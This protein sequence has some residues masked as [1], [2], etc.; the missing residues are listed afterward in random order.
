MDWIPPLAE[1]A[2]GLALSPPQYA[3]IAEPVEAWHHVAGLLTAAQ[4]DGAAL[5]Q[6]R[7]HALHPL[8]WAG[9]SWGGQTAPSHRRCSSRCHARKGREATVTGRPGEGWKKWP[10]P[11]RRKPSQLPR[12][13]FPCQPTSAAASTAPGCP[14]YLKLAGVGKILQWL[15]GQAWRAAKNNLPSTAPAPRPHSAL[16]T[17]QPAQLESGQKPAWWGWVPHSKQQGTPGHNPSLV[18][19][20]GYVS[21]HPSVTTEAVAQDTVISETI[22]LFSGTPGFWKLH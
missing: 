3:F 6:L 13:R 4:A 10:D 11:S 19:S 18:S 22:A 7:G 20:L 14:G 17:S 16:Q 2:I 5:L 8:R 12:V 1:G 15:W 9:G 21:V